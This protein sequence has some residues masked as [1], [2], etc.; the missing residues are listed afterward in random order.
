MSG[1]EIAG[2]VLAILPLVVNQLDNYARGLETFRA[3]RRY[4]LELEICS[5]TLS[6]QCAIFLNTL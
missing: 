1:V 5:S 3:L 2:L 6:A 4:K